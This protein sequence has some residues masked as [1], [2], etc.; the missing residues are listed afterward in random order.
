MDQRHWW[1]DQKKNKALNLREEAVVDFFKSHR[2]EVL[3][4]DPASPLL[5]FDVQK[6]WEPLCP[7]LDVPVP[8]TNINNSNEVRFVFNTIK[9]VAW[10]A[11]NV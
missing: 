3:S 5:V 8:E 10:Q 7:F 9:V 6:G 4:H 2:N 1:R 11:I